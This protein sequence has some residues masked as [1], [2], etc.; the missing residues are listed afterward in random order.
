MKTY[1]Q[2]ARDILMKKTSLIHSVLTGIIFILFSVSCARSSED[3]QLWYDKPATVWTEALPIGNGS[4]GGMI[5][6]APANDHIQFNEQTLWL[7]DQKA[8][9]SY[10][11]FGDLFLDFPSLQAGDYRRELNLGNA[12]HR[13]SFTSNGVHYVR[14]AFSSYP[15]QVMVIRLSA[16]KPGAITGTIRLTDVRNSAVSVQGNK[17]SFAGA[18]P[19]KLAYEAQVLVQNEKGEIHPVDGGL[20]VSNA[21]TVT[22]LLAAGTNFANSPQKGWR[23]E[24]PGKKLAERLEKALK[25]GYEPLRAAHIADYQSLY[26]RVNLKLGASRDDLPTDRRVVESKKNGSDPGLDALFFQYGR[27]LLIS[28][29]RPGGLPANLQGI[30]NADIKPAWYSGYTTNINVEMNYWLAE[31]TNLSECHEPLFD[32][33]RNLAFVRKKNEQP[34][35]AAKRGWTIY[36]TNNPMCGNSKWGVHRPGSAWLS[37]HLWTH[38]AYTGDREFLKNTAYPILKEV[39]EYWEDHLV[40]GPDGKLITPDGWSPEHGP[41]EVN[42]KITLKEGDRT[43]QPGASYDQQIVWDLFT[44]YIDASEELGID[45]DYRAKVAGMRAQLLGPKIGRWGQLQEWMQDVDQEK[46]QHRHVSHLFALHPGRQIDPLT[47]PEWAQ[48]AKVSLSARGDGGTGW[49]KAWKINFWA[50][51]ADGDRAY[52]LLRGL[53]T[54][55]VGKAGSGGVYANLFDAHPPFQIDG[56]FGATSGIAEMLLQSHVRKEGAYVIDL[57]PALPQAW[58]E[59]SVTGLRARGG[60]EVAMEWKGGKLTH[61]TIRSLLG[62]PAIVRIGGK[63][64]ELNLKAGETYTFGK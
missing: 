63:T 30:W 17:I 58:P 26:G 15:D 22:I 28:S 52:K 33:V 35:I 6:G 57:L 16:D 49:S 60:F 38:Y 20:S 62:N 13:V 4:L 51:L 25:K 2:P 64:E 47:T 53:L 43:P 9:G 48:A 1:R 39:V 46:D 14:E 29:S 23:G 34:D 19:N 45:A 5:F 36:C 55:V 61:A 56:N 41:V 8:I 37:Q 54:L 12:I 50:R 31:P 3:E 10:Q 18:L 21:D 44:N 40:K 27:Y 42:G 32:W 59:G 11:P 24:L 7:G